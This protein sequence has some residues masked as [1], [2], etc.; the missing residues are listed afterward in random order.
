MLQAKDA[1]ITYFEESIAE[2]DSLLE[3]NSQLMA[4][5]SLEI[6]KK[7]GK[8]KLQKNIIMDKET[9]L[10]EMDDLVLDLRCRLR[11]SQER[12]REMEARLS[13]DYERRLAAWYKQLVT[14]VNTRPKPQTRRAE[15]S[16]EENK[17][18]AVI[19]SFFKSPRSNELNTAFPFEYL[20]SPSRSYENSYQNSPHK[21]RDIGSKTSVISNS[22]LNEVNLASHNARGQMSPNRY[23]PSAPMGGIFFSDKSPQNQRGSSNRQDFTRCNLFQRRGTD[24]RKNPFTSTNSRPPD[25][26][27][28]SI[29]NR[30]SNV[31]V[32]LPIKKSTPTEDNSTVTRRVQFLTAKLKECEQQ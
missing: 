27:M 18:N 16:R 14:I 22:M 4:E 32:G 10:A 2:R 17:Q 9:N 23:P 11:K 19:H 29:I 7:D 5:N 21:D 1:E 26:G 20:K 12:T 28:L 31:G 15:E 6:E 13:H 30:L 8:I 3:K 25:M 24:Q